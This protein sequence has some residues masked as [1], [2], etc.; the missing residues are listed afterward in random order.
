VGQYPRFAPCMCVRAVEPLR[1]SIIPA[2]C[3]TLPFGV[4]T[5]ART[6]SLKGI[7]RI[8]CAGKNP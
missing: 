6:F 7:Y 1:D 3:L 2:G 8:G 4:P 5:L